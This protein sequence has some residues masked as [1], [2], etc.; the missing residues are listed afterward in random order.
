MSFYASR[1]IYLAFYNELSMN[2]DTAPQML[3][4]ILQHMDVKHISCTDN[5]SINNNQT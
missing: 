3:N 1:K 2:M 5:T 4:I